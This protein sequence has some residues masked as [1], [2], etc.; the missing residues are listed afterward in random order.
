MLFFIPTRVPSADGRDK[1]EQHF[2]AAWPGLAGSSLGV[3]HLE[4]RLSVRAGVRV[5][6]IIVVFCCC[7][8]ASQSASSAR[9]RRRSELGGC[10]VYVCVH[11]CVCD[12]ILPCNVPWGFWHTII[13]I[14][15]YRSNRFA[16]DRNCDSW[17]KPVRNRVSLWHSVNATDLRDFVPRLTVKHS[18][19]YAC[20]VRELLLVS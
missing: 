16:L 19:L 3:E 7:F 8:R 9:R 17:C 12:I 14:K 15:V 11:A 1:T 6:L 5:R 10:R 20:E 2:A 13:V 4:D 18:P